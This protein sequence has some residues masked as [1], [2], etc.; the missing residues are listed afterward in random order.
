MINAFG[1]IFGYLGYQVHARNFF[2][3]LD[4]L[5]PVCL[6]SSNPNAQ[7]FP[8]DP[9]LAQML[10]RTAQIDLSQPGICIDYANNFHRFHSA[11][12]IGYTVFEYTRLGAD[13][14][15]GLSQVDAIWITSDF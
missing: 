12:R 2:R 8:V 3:A 13:W 14:I 4:R 6:T 7:R 15:N 1:P 5:E 9:Q 11:F 10:A